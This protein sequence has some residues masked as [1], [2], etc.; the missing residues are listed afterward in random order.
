MSFDAKKLY[1]L[2]PAFYRIRDIELGRKLQSSDENGP[3]KALLSIIAE[4]VAILEEDLEQLYDDQF[5]ETAAEW[6]IP[7]IGDLVGTRGLSSIPDALFSQRAEV[8]NTI[9]YRR[10]KGTAAILEQLARDVTGWNANVVE[11]F[12][13]LATTQFLNHLRPGNLSTASLKDS[14]ALRNFNTP[15]DKMTRT[16]DVR[17]IEKK[18][19]KYNI[20][21]VG[22]FLWRLDNFS[23][24][25]C[26]AF[27]VD[28]LRY[29]FDALGRD[30]QLYSKPETEKEITHLAERINVP[31]P[32]TSW[33]MHKYP[34]DYYGKGKGLLIYTDGKKISLPDDSLDDDVVPSG[35]PAKKIS[36]IITICNLGDLKDGSGNIGWVN[37]PLDKIAIDPVLGRIAFPSS[38]TKLIPQNVHVT[39]NYGFS[40]KTGGG[41]YGRSD[42]FSNKLLPL[43]KVPSGEKTIK[44]A[45]EK[46]AVSGGVVEIE[47][48]E[49]YE[50]ALEINVAAGTKIELRAADKC[51]PVLLLKGKLTI[52]GGENAE[53]SLNGLLIC[54]NYL[55]FPAKD[56]KLR[57]FQAQH[58]T[59]L[60]GS[61]L[62]EDNV[63]AY[64]LYVEMPDV[65]VE[66]NRCITGVIRATDEASIKISDSIIDASGE[67]EIAFAGLSGEQFGARLTVQNST[68]I[69]KVYSRVIELASNSIFLSPVISERFQEG[70]MRFTY[71]PAGSSVPR[72]YHCQPQNPAD[73]ARLRPIFISKQ[74]G[75]AEYCQLSQFCA[76]EIRGGA[77]DES[78]MGAFHIL[79]QPQREAN[80]RKRL[81]EYLRFGL[82]AG[83]FYAS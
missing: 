25:E 7:Y 75:E 42:S 9:A 37:L 62:I 12:Q 20:P 70:C 22:I 32:I 39:Y 68:I 80:L 61:A 44:L 51:R 17:H 21:N 79:Y 31:M 4:Q 15:F 27:K 29:K 30:V 55:Y 71:F 36:D 34:E 2:L 28:D 33:V 72:A 65:I 66:L 73:A 5:I 64:R 53:V 26:P 58:C 3:L 23:L 24:T 35:P 77:D 74:Y 52:T 43:I 59:L 56:N 81:D 69:G 54:N 16:V 13:L 18:R 47:N 38:P 50:E 67:T 60:P 82:E 11:Y 41:E 14:E 10:R 46:L 40:A 49:C 45:L 8:A 63:S 19:G 48:N 78:E 83:I 76:A 6:A 1:E 57:Y